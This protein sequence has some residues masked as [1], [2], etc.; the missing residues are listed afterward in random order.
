MAEM[1]QCADE[2][3]ITGLF[4]KTI[5]LICVCGFP[6]CKCFPVQPITSYQCGITEDEELGREAVACPYMVFPPHGYSEWKQPR[7]FR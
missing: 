7:E 2:S 4:R 6:W 1:E 3:L 5:A